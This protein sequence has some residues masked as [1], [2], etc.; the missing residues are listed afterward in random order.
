[1]SAQLQFAGIVKEHKRCERCRGWFPDE[2]LTVC[3]KGPVRKRDY[4]LDHVDDRFSTTMTWVDVPCCYPC[5]TL[6]KLRDMLGA[7][8]A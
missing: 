7:P 1:V 6:L 4:F 2:E 8:S 3:S 5:S